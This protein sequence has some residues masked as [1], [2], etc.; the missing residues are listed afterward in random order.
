M[1]LAVNH[2]IDALEEGRDN[3]VLVRVVSLTGFGLRDAADGAVITGVPAAPIVSGRILGGLLDNQLIG[4]ME[5]GSHRRLVAG[6]V[7]DE[8]A[9]SAGMICGGQAQ[10]LITPVADFPQ[11]LRSWLSEA[12]PLTLVAAADGNSGDLVVSKREAAG[13][14]GPGFEHATEEVLAEARSQLAEGATTTTT[15]EIGGVSL[16]FSAIVP[17]TRFLVVG[18]GPMA[19]AIASQGELMG[20]AVETKEESGNGISFVSD[21]GPADGVAVLSHDP[22]IDVPVI[23]AALKSS[24][25]YIGGMGSRNT[26]RRRREALAKLGH[27]EAE[28]SRVHG[29]IGLDLGSR[30]PA[31]TAVAIAAEFL[32]ARSGKKP[33]SLT[34][35]SG[36]ING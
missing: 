18:S 29:P 15:K 12:L 17:A 3:D 26:Q 7:A 35:A 30:T 33:Q 19:E 21:A 8:A 6:T 24:I 11:E 4:E 5:A 22:D 14:L 9:T 34:G 2:L 13:S 1:E 20:W 36:S 28:M 32:A 27:S 31:E 25:G 10:L 23:S 16:L